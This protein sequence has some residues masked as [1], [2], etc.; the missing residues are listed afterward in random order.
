M[1]LTDFWRRWRCKHL[2]ETEGQRAAAARQSAEALATI[3]ANHA[4]DH[5][6]PDGDCDRSG[7]G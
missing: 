4:R 1:P 3:V 2:R 6:P 5:A 7:A